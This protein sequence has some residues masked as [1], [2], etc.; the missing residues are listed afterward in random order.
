MFF[1]DKNTVKFFSSSKGVLD[2]YPI[3]LAKD[4]FPKWLNTA[5]KDF[6]D[7]IQ[8]TYPSKH[9][10]SVHRCPGIVGLLTK[11]F[12]L[13]AWQDFSITTNADGSYRWNTALQ[14]NDYSDVNHI[15]QDVKVHDF[16]LLLKYLPLKKDSF[17][18]IL[19]LHTPWFV[20]GPKNVKYLFLPISYS[21]SDS[22]FV[23]PG[24][25]DTSITNEILINIHWNE[26]DNT[27]VIKAGT[28]LMQII[29][30]EDKHYSLEVGRADRNILEEHNSKLF[31]LFNTFVRN[32][33]K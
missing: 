4:N 23:Y 8:G 6:S 22:F 21:D 10:H 31:K 16:D 24:I 33:N 27:R 7:K 20:Y 29:P 5:R 26:L 30:F 17:N 28:P 14:I 25:L 13:K 1:K 2:Y 12:V 15:I 9:S 19:K 18:I 3:E 32:Y 11:G